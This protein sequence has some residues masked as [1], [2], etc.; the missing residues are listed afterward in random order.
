MTSPDPQP[1]QDATTLLEAI[2]AAQ[3]A[4]F[5]EQF[6]ATADGDVRCGACS[7]EI[8]AEQLVVHH[9]DRLEGASD[10]ADEMLVARVECSECGVRG[11]LTLGYGPNA[12]EA[13]IAVLRRLP[14]SRD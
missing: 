4:G 5:S 6:I 13:D 1:A 8:P 2:D 14:D 3:A 9:Q 10:A 7:A 11:V 12:D